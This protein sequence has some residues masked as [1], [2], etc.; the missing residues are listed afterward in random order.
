[1][2]LKDPLSRWNSRDSQHNSRLAS[3]ASMNWSDLFKPLNA[4]SDL[5]DMEKSTP[6]D[7]IASSGPHLFIWK[8]YW[9]SACGATLVTILVPVIAG[10]VF[11]SVTRFLM[12]HR[13]LWVPIPMI[14][15]IVLALVLNIVPTTRT[16]LTT[17]ILLIFLIIGPAVVTAAITLLSV[18]KSGKHQLLWCGFTITLCFSL[19]L[20]NFRSNNPPTTIL[21]FATTMVPAYLMITHL[22]S[23][24]TGLSSLLRVP[25]RAVLRGS[26]GSKGNI[27]REALRVGICTVCYIIANCYWIYCP[28][29]G[30]L[31]TILFVILGI[32]R[33]VRNGAETLSENPTSSALNPRRAPI[34]FRFWIAFQVVWIV[35][36]AADNHVPDNI[37]GMFIS[38]FPMTAI[39]MYW[40]YLDYKVRFD[41]FFRT[42]V[43]RH[44]RQVVAV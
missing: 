30:A 3:N 4:S 31:A 1:M 42:R 18:S 41:K 40:V 14:F 15:L 28:D 17:R 10:P 11:R 9:V 5:S 27:K 19:W 39:F 25:Y 2:N 20:D 29:S 21:P 23:Q 43:R 35:C 6:I 24:G 38:L 7:A 13:M 37:R 36:A 12:R 22:R 32:N 44:S 8:Q 16:L 34:A 33:V 26:N